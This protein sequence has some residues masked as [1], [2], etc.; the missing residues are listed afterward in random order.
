MLKIIIIWCLKL[1]VCYILML[2]SLFETNYFN[3]MYF[4]DGINLIFNTFDTFNNHKLQLKFALYYAKLQHIFLI[5]ISDIFLRKFYMKSNKCEMPSEIFAHFINGTFDFI[6]VIQYLAL[7]ILKF[8]FGVCKR[9]VNIHFKFF[10][11]ILKYRYKINMRDIVLLLLKDSE[12]LHS[13]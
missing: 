7:F 8:L 2:E 1:Y 11:L 9:S 4:V 10:L 6:A 12:F 13:L 5:N 3:K